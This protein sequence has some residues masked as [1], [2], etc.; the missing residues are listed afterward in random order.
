MFTVD[1][2]REI[3][4]AA[5]AE[6]AVEW[7]LFALPGEPPVISPAMAK[8]VLAAAGGRDGVMLGRIGKAWGE[9]IDVVPLSAPNGSS[10]ERSAEAEPESEKPDEGMLSKMIASHPA[11]WWRS[12]LED[13]LS[14][15]LQL[16]ADGIYRLETGET[17]WRTT[18]PDIRRAIVDAYIRWL[19]QR[20]EIGKLTAQVFDDNRPEWMSK[21]WSVATLFDLTFSDMVEAAQRSANEPPF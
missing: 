8:F 19:D 16:Y 17:T 15:K 9:P 1:E 7:S 11:G 4:E 10:P 20:D 21:A 2:L 14:R 3:A 12:Q 13:H 6:M 5:Q 18:A